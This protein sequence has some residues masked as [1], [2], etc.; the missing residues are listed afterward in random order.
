MDSQD[1][2]IGGDRGYM[3]KVSTVA[4]HHSPLALALVRIHVQ[5]CNTHSPGKHMHYHTLLCDPLH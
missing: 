4:V 1:G 3:Q 2:H 5:H